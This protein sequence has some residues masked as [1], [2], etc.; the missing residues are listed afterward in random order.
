MDRAGEV[1]Y[2]DVTMLRGLCPLSEYVI[3]TLRSWNLDAR[4]EE[5][6]DLMQAGRLTVQQVL[7]DH[8]ALVTFDS[9][10]VLASA[11]VA[12]D[13]FID[14]YLKASMLIRSRP[15]EAARLFNT[16]PA[17]ARAFR[18]GKS[19]VLVGVDGHYLPASEALMIDDGAQPS[20]GLFPATQWTQVIEVIQ[21]GADEAAWA[22]LGEF[23]EQYR[24]AIYGFF[25]RRGCT[26]EQAEEYTQ[27]F[28]LT[29]I[30]ARWDAGEGFLFKAKRD[31]RRRFRAF[32]CHVLWAF[33]KDQWKAGQALKA[34]GR[35]TH[36]PL[37][38]FE[39]PDVEGESR[40]LAEIS[41]D[42][43]RAVGLEILKKAAGDSTRSKYLL[44][45]FQGTLSQ[46]EAAAE[47]G[48]K[49]NAFK[50]AYDRFKKSLRANLRQEVSKLVGPDPK[51][52]DDEIRYLM[53]VF[54][55]SAP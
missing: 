9:P 7:A 48:M 54:A 42:L 51:D 29:R 41:T 4:L 32:L 6:F 18:G 5:W 35:T 47:L 13:Q 31:Q 24:P 43:D 26:H 34:G 37:D 20:S 55:R 28:F 50:Q 17:V 36:V 53:S 45:H 46:A 16:D 8:P 21:Q 22:A 33:L 27:E 23:C 12:L 2:G 25:R 40:A 3:H 19:L 30:H 52:I 10:E 38:G 49:E 14:A 44:Q 15:V 11:R 1:D 39:F